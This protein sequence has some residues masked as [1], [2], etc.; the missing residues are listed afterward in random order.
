M[1]YFVTYWLL[2]KNIFHVTGRLLPNFCVRCFA[3]EGYRNY[4]TLIEMI[5]YRVRFGLEI[6]WALP[7][8]SDD[9]SDVFFSRRPREIRSGRRRARIIF[10]VVDSSPAARAGFVCCRGT[11]HGRRSFGVIRMLSRQARGRER[12]PLHRPFSLSGS[13]DIFHL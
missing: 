13:E 4:N 2:F 1:Y 12:R 10:V 9:I 6:L 3:Y 11:Y 8:A 5:G 7:A